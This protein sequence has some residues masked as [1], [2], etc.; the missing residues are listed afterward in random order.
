LIFCY[1]IVLGGGT[2]GSRI[3]LIE[4]DSSLSGRAGFPALISFNSR[5]YSLFIRK[6]SCS[7]TLD[8]FYGLLFTFWD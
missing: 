7:Y 6:S 4:G 2:G 1:D 8:S 3:G 5:S